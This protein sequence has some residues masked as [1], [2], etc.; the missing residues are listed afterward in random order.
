MGVEQAQFKLE[1]RVELPWKRSLLEKRELDLNKEYPRSTF[2][3]F[4]HRLVIPGKKVPAPWRFIE[5]SQRV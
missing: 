4:S 5:S 2:E 1:K 3:L